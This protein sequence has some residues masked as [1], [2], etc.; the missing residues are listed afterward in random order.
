MRPQ[1][2]SLNP[3]KYLFWEIVNISRPDSRVDHYT[4]LVCVLLFLCIFV[5]MLVH[6]QIL[7]MPILQFQCIIL[8][9]KCIF[10][11]ILNVY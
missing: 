10:F 11:K 4:T 9:I 3:F 7:K 5:L 6:L 8:S 1:F 2:K